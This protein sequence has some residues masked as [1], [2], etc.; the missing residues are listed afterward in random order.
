MMKILSYRTAVIALVVLYITGCKQEEYQVPVPESGL[1]NDCIK[2]SNGPNMPGVDMEFMYAIAI[3]KSEGKLVSAQ[4]EASIAGASETYID[5]HSYHTDD[6]G[7]DVGVIVTEPSTNEGLTTKVNFSLDTNAATLRFFYRPSL[8]SVDQEVSFV[9]SATSSNGQ[10]VSYNMG[11]YKIRRMERA[12]NISVADGQQS[13]ISIEDMKAYNATDAS[14]RSEAIDLVYLHRTIPGIT[15]GHALIAPAADA[16]YRPGLILPAGVRRDAKILKAWN[17]RDIQ[18][19]PNVTGN[20][21]FV[22]LDDEDFKSIDLQAAPNYAINMK[23]QSG[24]WIETTDRKYRAFV[25]LNSVNDAGKSA[26]LSI[27]RYRM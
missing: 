5:R 7:Q 9:F 20:N 26:V 25:Y 10:T 19:E 13:F 14:S 18:L 4:V 21:T 23:A 17:I 16:I 1:Q 11:P 3:Q 2:K 6:N 8:A 15:F 22:Y 27:K 12:L 24:V